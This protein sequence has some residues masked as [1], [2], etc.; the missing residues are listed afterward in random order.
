MGAERLWLWQLFCN[1]DI[2][3]VFIWDLDNV[4]DVP[5]MC[6]FISMWSMQLC[7]QNS[8]DVDEEYKIGKDTS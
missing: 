5:E 8:K 2:W 6:W 4:D 3:Y 1:E 7:H